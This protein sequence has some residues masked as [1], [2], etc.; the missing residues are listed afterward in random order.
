MEHQ[1]L[2]PSE[3]ITQANVDLAYL[4]WLSAS[5]QESGPQ[6]PMQ[7][8]VAGGDERIELSVLR[9]ASGVSPALFTAL[10]K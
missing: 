9:S 5:M 4:R 6:E 8:Q 3:P 10:A 1:T 7:I 2:P